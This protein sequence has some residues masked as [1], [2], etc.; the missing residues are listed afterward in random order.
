MVRRI[1]IPKILLGNSIYPPFND[2]GCHD[3]HHESRR[4]GIAMDKPT[5]GGSRAHQE[6]GRPNLGTAI[7]KLLSRCL[8]VT[9]LLLLM[10]MVTVMPL[11]E[12]QNW[13]L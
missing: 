13:S 4:S 9:L 2:G 11:S 1:P 7:R 5:L 12:P 3:T 10:M 8:L 6:V